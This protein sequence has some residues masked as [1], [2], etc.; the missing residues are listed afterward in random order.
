MTAESVLIRNAKTEVQIFVNGFLIPF[1]SFILSLFVTCFLISLLL[2]YNFFATFIILLVFSIAYILISKYYS[3][4]LSDIGKIRQEHDKYIL[5]YLLQ[6]LR[7]IV[8]VKIFNL[9]K[10]YLERFSKK[11][12]NWPRL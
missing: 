11:M 5:K 12:T 4:L 10:Y 3:K 9:E 8:E 1:L 6:S 7:S 2:V